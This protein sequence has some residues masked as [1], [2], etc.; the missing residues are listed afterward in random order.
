LDGENKDLKSYIKEKSHNFDEMKSI[1]NL[2]HGEVS[3]MKKLQSTALK[4]QV[5]YQ[6]IIKEQVKD[7]VNEQAKQQAKEQVNEEIKKQAKEQVN[8]H[9]NEQIN[10]QVKEKVKKQIKEQVKEQVKEHVKEQINEQVKEKVKEQIKEQVREQV[11]EQ[12][13]GQDKEVKEQVEEDILNPIITEDDSLTEL[14]DDSFSDL[15]NLYTNSVIK[16]PDLPKLNIMQ[17]LSLIPEIKSEIKTTQVDKDSPFLNSKDSTKPNSKNLPIDIR[18]NSDFNEEFME[19]YENF[20][21]SWRKE[22]EKI[23]L[24]KYIFI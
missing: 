18:K 11:N 19:Y 23:N 3:E 7:Q 13:K 24:S 22:C 15:G 6:V 10:E 2:L 1:L 12:T 21:P 17:R 16:K 9:V 14:S 5:N 4:E 8:E 20:S